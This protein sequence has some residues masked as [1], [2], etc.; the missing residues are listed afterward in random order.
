MADKKAR[1]QA[2]NIEQLVGVRGRFRSLI[3]Q[4]PNYF[5]NLEESAFKPVLPIKANSTFEEIG[6]VGYQP[7]TERLEATIYIKQPSGYGGGLCGPGSHEYVRFYASWDNGGSW[8]DLGLCALNV[9]DIPKT[10][11]KRRLEYAVTRR[12]DFHRRPCFAPQIV[13]IRAILSW[14]AVPPA[15]TPNHNPVWG[16]IHNTRILIEPRRFWFV[17]DLLEAVDLKLKPEIAELLDDNAQLEVAAKPLGIAKLQQLYRGQDVPA[18]RFAHAQ[19][20]ALHQSPLLT[21]QLMAPAAGGVLEQL[22]L[23]AKGIDLADLFAIG[24]GN[25]SY[26]ELES[27]GYDPDDDSLVGIVRIKKSAGYSGGPCSHG[28]LEYVTFWADL[29]GN[30]TFETCVGTASVRVYDVAIPKEGLEYAVHIPADLVRERIPCLSGP[31]VIPIRAILSWATPVPCATP[32]ATP[33]W[34]NRMETFVHVKPGRRVIEGELDPL[35]S[36]VGGIPVG[37]IDGNGLAQNA[38]AVTTG[39]YFNHA[40]F[41]GRINLAGKIINGTAL[42]RYRVMIRKHNVGS[43]QPLNLEPNGFLQTVVTPGPTTTTSTHH[44]GGDGYYGYEDFSANHYVEGNILAIWQTGAGEHGQIYDLRVDVK[45]PGN[46][47]VDIKSNVVV[48]EIDN[49]A[50]VL[51]LGFTTLAGDCAH[52]DEGAVFN[53]TFSVNDPHFGS[54][55]FAILPPGPAG[56][57]L[58]VPPSGASIYLAGAIADPGVSTTFTLNTAGMAPCGYALVLNAWDRTNVNSGASNNYNSDSVGFCLGSPPEG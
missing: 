58:P 50:P 18:K 45:D 7:Q 47:L 15:N 36:S 39:A 8:T 49:E 27:V 52:F 20:A 12:Y 53:G 16:E 54:F 40:P 51:S 30:G 5:G 46:P 55:S 13:L 22:G 25:T 33:T 44:A 23:D 38:V 34:G 26:E 3:L 56:G 4:N 32:N 35:L 9:W 31:R 37:N 6:S 42:T 17:K 14:N 57:V 41:G 48:V 11:N 2:G 43:F 1:I 19:L 28:S 21:A 24:D 10:S 29:N